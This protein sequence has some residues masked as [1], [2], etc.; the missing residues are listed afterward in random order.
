M[1]PWILVIDIRS[2]PT[3]FFQ[4]LL[5]DCRDLH[6]FRAQEH[7]LLMR[8]V[9]LLRQVATLNSSL[10]METATYVA[11][12]LH[13]EQALTRKSPFARSESLGEVRSHFRV[14]ALLMVLPGNTFIQGYAFLP[15]KIFMQ[16][17]QVKVPLCWFVPLQLRW[18]NAFIVKAEA[19][20][21]GI[22]FSVLT[23]PIKRAITFS[24]YRTNHILSY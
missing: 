7:C 11:E 16:L 14:R 18:R 15:L 17:H 5:F 23:W 21:S 19:S 9:L 4:S 1:S 3:S 10:F 22:K 24:Q 13:M 8:T 6:T 2:S 12:K 20:S